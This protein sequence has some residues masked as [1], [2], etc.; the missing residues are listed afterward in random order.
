MDESN[1]QQEAAGELPVPEEEY[2]EPGS[3]EADERVDNAEG[4]QDDQPKYDGGS[5]PPVAEDSPEELAERQRQERVAEEEQQ[6]Q[7]QEPLSDEDRLRAGLPAE[8]PRAPEPP[9]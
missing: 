2:M 9:A 1:E 7:S 5:V 4:E 3:A 8:E 6:R